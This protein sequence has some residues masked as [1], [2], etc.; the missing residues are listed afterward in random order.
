MGLRGKGAAGS[1]GT[2]GLEELRGG[3]GRGRGTEMKEIKEKAAYGSE[4]ISGQRSVV[5]GR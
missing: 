5:R 2:K 4:A 1:E 3:K